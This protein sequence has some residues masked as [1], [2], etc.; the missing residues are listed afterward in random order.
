[1]LSKE[2]ESSRIS[3]CNLF[4]VLDFFSLSLLDRYYIRKGPRVIFLKRTGEG[5]RSVY[6]RG[7]RLLFKIK[8]LGGSRWHNYLLFG[9]HLKQIPPV[10]LRAPQGRNPPFG[11]AP[12]A[13]L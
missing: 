1:M 11:L 8:G 3:F 7:L 9:L 6:I 5:S 10:R 2:T 13:P 12:Q 4:A